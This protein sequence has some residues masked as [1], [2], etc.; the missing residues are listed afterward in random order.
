MTQLSTLVR[1]AFEKNQATNM[2]NPKMTRRANTIV[3]IAYGK[4]EFVVEDSELPGPEE[5]LLTTTREKFAGMLR[6]NV[7]QVGGRYLL[8]QGIPNVCL[9]GRSFQKG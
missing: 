8:Y 1:Q 3:E 4:T 2:S 6:E 9:C 7:K 5:P